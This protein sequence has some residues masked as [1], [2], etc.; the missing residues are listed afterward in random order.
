[1]SYLCGTFLEGCPFLM[2]VRPLSLDGNKL[3]I[4]DISGQHNHSL[5][6][7]RYYHNDDCLTHTIGSIQTHA[8]AKALG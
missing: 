1:M 7:V 5:S 4:Q 8:K 6:R 2:K 3:V